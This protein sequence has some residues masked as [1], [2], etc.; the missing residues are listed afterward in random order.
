M[1]TIIRTYFNFIKEDWG[2]FLEFSME[3]VQMDPNNKKI[4]TLAMEVEPFT[5]TNPKFSKWADK[6]LDATFGTRPKISIGMR[7]SGT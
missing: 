5:V 1:K 7:M 2:L 6:R 3:L 4:S